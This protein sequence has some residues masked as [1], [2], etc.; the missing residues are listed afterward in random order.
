M[1]ADVENAYTLIL[2]DENGP[3]SAT[4]Y[5][6]EDEAWR[7][8]DRAV[9]ERC[10]MRPRYRRVLDPEAIARLADAWRSGYPERRFWQILAHRLPTVVTETARTPEPIRD[11]GQ[12]V[13]S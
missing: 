10:R 4:V 8:L 6:T 5:A 3:A 1:A 7:A 12:P 11:D 2:G 9:R 13:A